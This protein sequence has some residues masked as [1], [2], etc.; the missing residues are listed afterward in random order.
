MDVTEVTLATTVKIRGKIEPAGKVVVVNQ[1]EFDQLKAV[2]AISSTA[3]TPI[4]DALIADR[5]ALEQL[6]A[7]KGEVIQTLGSELTA[8]EARA[9]EAEAQRDLLQDRVLELQAQ[10]AATIEPTDTAGKP[11]TDDQHT[12]AVKT[13]SKKTG[14]GSTKG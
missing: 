1:T 12:E 8:M 6:I 9:I 5:D 2:G 3:A 4:A 7:T 11:A 13:T 14:S 10:I